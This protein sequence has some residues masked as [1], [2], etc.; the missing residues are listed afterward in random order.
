MKKL[1]VAGTLAALICMSWTSGAVAQ[2]PPGGA[3]SP[4]AAAPGAPGMASRD[5]GLMLRLGG[6]V[7]GCTDDWCDHIDPMVGL[8]LVA[9]YRIMKYVAAGLHT[10]FLFG[11]PDSNYADRAWNL[12]IGAEGR[13]I[14]PYKQFE[15]W[16]A[17]SLGYSRFMATR[18]EC[19]MGVCGDGQWW[20][21]AF[22][23]G[24]GFGADYYF[25]RSI[26]AGLSFYLYKPWPDQLC[27]DT[28]ISDTDCNDMSKDDL[29][30]IGIIW[31][32]SAVVTLFRCFY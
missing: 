1:F 31:S 14:Y 20:M 5:Q 7:D 4:G 22:A 11:D 12:Y 24:F 30:D 17:F 16:G 13:G 23:V 32:I 18:E 10:A 8:R 27:T 3:S 21:N 9:L 25:T 6:G 28:S 2:A 15:L 26:A 19:A 29:D